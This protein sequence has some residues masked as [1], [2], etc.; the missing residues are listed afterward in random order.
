MK[1]VLA[2][3]KNYK[4]YYNHVTHQLYDLGY[5]TL[6]YD[7]GGLGGGIEFNEELPEMKSKGYNAKIPFKPKIIADALERTD[8]K[9]VWL[10]TDIEVLERFDEVWEEDFDV[11]VTVRMV[12]GEKLAQFVRVPDPEA[13][14]FM[15]SG[16]VFIRNTKRSKSFMRRWE[17]SVEG[18]K[19]GSD[20]EA[21]TKMI[22][23]T[24]GDEWERERTYGVGGAQVYTFPVE[25]YNY[26]F[27][28][29]PYSK[30]GA[31][32][33]HYPGIRRKILDNHIKECS[34]C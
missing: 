7:L 33:I 24:A 10:D 27:Q 32:I 5:E 21:I 13:T 4:K 19:F 29:M 11:G 20:Q 18:T 25:I 16:V 34:R 22:R 23:K 6:T 9:L 1:V 26:N 28:G 15:N 3:N 14:G 12:F 30:R 17:T 2:A 8:E 31:K